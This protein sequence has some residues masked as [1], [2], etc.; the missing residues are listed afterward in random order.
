M[1][2]PLHIII[3]LEQEKRIADH[4]V[5][6]RV[7]SPDDLA[8]DI[9]ATAYWMDTGK[10]MDFHI[11]LKTKQPRIEIQSTTRESW[12]ATWFCDQVLSIWKAIKT[13]IFPPKDQGWHCS[14][15][16]CGYW[17]LCKGGYK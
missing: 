6:S 2:I 16:W 17:N 8:Q 4:K 9:Q 11:A 13:G 7:F 15:R 5:K 10:P 3:D 12:H 14:E 1:G